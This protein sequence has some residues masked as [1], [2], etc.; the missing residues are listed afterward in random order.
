MKIEG[1]VKKELDRLK[2]KYVITVTD[3]AQNNVLFTCKKY[4]ISV[5]REELRRPGQ[6]TYQL[7]N[8]DAA[9]INNDIITFSNSKGIKVP[10]SMIDIPLIYWIPKM[11]KNPIGKRFIAGSKLCSIKLLSKYFLKL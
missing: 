8:K 4:Y 2:E 3:K 6:L 5:V 11:H 10:D 1:N 7:S 9:S